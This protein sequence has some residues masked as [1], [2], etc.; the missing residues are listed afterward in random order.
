MQLQVAGRLDL[1]E[2][3][4]RSILELHPTHGAA[5]YCIG[6]LLVQLRRPADGLPHLL[7][8]LNAH[9]EIADYWLGYLEALLL[10]GEHGEAASTLALARRH[11]LTG[12]A[13]DE[14]AQRLESSLAHAAAPATPPARSNEPAAVRN[15]ARA[16]R[17][18]DAHASRRQASVLALVKEG[19][20]RDALPLARDLTERFPE[21]GAGWK[22]FAAMLWAAG[23]QE[24]ALAAMHASVRLL[25]ADAEAHANL[26]T[27]LNKMRRIDEAEK[28][29]L[30]ALKIDPNFAPAHSQLADNYQLQGRY[31]DAEASFRRALGACPGGF[32]AAGDEVHTGFLF[33]LNHNPDVDADTL[34]AEHCRV[35][36]C[37]EKSAP[38]V[39]ARHANDPTPERCLQVGFVSADL[40]CHAVAN[41]I[42]PV[43]REWQDK[44]SLR[45]TIYYTHASEDEVSRRLRG[46]VSRWVPV[47]GESNAQLAQRIEGD[48]IDILIDV[49][50]YT[51][52]HRLGAF[53]RKPAP[54]QASWLG[55]PS[56]TGLRSMDYYLT[57]RHFLPP[58]EFDRY[59]IEKLAYLPAVWPF[60]PHESAPPVNRL[61]A[62]TSGWLTFGSFNRLGKINESTVRLWSQL[63]R[64][65]P[66][67][68]MLIAGVPLDRQHLQLINWFGEAGIA[69]ERLTFE[70][71]SN[72]EALLALHSQVDIVLE[73][74]PYTGCTTTNHALWM[75]L[76]TLT[77][78]G[79]TPAS[80]LAAANLG[81]LGLDEFIA[82]SPAEFVAKGVGWAKDLPGLAALR[83]G[84]RAR[85]LSASARQPAFVAAGI[86]QALRHMWRQW[87]AGLPAESFEIAG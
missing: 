86:E 48:S 77:L 8:A 82:A 30:H 56:T 67:A 61:P 43:L 17:R 71:W 26:G 7:A 79:R 34:F 78:V 65:V 81:H 33:M 36:A 22:I 24:E 58:G 45:I 31:A 53:A 68:K 32:S 44:D 27:A 19:R 15:S 49:S 23:T 11:G 55:Y 2:P 80:R 84:L 39:R 72:L 1:A 21:Y 47:G 51:S 52:M 76:P 5:N 70:P 41:F 63:L 10:L 69:R 16:A 35:G 25:P 62:L 38:R 42:E 54:V 4:Y 18:R 83:A 9:P 74:T 46:Y 50:G 37:L 40:R 87:C 73:P 12:Q 29:L 20:F 13:T 14:F 3:I 75:G 28:C 59:F 66:Q 85:W 57:D 64:A 6:M 60:Q